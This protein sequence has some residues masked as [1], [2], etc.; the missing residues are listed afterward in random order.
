MGTPSVIGRQ[1][2]RG[3][4]TPVRTDERLDLARDGQAVLRDLPLERERL[5]TAGIGHHGARLGDD[6]RIIDRSVRVVHVALRLEC[7]VR[8]AVGDHRLGDA[9]SQRRRVVALGRGVI[10]AV[11]EAA[12][13]SASC[14]SASSS[15][16]TVKYRH[17]EDPV[18]READGCFPE[19]RSRPTRIASR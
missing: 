11:A 9:V 7:A 1:R 3:H 4:V 8:R 13:V 12:M 2:E 14:S 5:P 16:V 17:E 19:Q 18:R 10:G 6:Q 15:S